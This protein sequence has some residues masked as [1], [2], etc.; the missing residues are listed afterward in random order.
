V[1]GKVCLFGEFVGGGMILNENGRI[2]AE[3]WQALETRFVM[4]RLDKW[5]V[6]PNHLHGIVGLRPIRPDGGS[7]RNAGAQQRAPTPAPRE[8]KPIPMS[9]PLGDIV[10]AFKTA[11]TRR[12][13]VAA[14]TIGQ[15]FWQRN[16]YER[17]IRNAE[18]L[19]RIRRYIRENPARWAEDEE[20]PQNMQSTG[21][22]SL[23]D[24]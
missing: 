3:E 20:N 2:V 7:A 6:M 11:S 24:V 21:S 13:N 14:G 12:V 9:K 8:G 19:E 15:R 5:V 10:G 22:T 4:V 23:A 17:V 16:F 18:E 1:Q